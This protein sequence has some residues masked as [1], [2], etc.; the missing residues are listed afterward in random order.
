MSRTLGRPK[1]LSRTLIHRGR[2]F[3]VASCELRYQNGLRARNE[4]VLHAGAAVFA[5]IPAPNRILLVRQYRHAAGDY[6]WEIPAGRLERGEDPLAA[7]KRELAEECGLAARRWKKACAFYPAPGYTSEVMHLFF[8]FD[9]RPAPAGKT[10]DHDEEIETREF[11]RARFERLVSKGSIRDGKTL[12]A[13]AM[14][15]LGF[16]DL[17]RRHA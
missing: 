16:W 8:A 11:T 7:A 14:L 2:I 13:A 15:S 9:L 3:D 4:L 10:P 6:M 17:A 5:P 12:A 1:E